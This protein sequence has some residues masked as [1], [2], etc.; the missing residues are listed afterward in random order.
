MRRIVA[1]IG[2][3]LLALTPSLWADTLT[4]V[5]DD[6][7]PFNCAPDSDAPGF[8]VETA[9]QAFALSGYTIKYGTRPW[10]RAISDVR[11]GKY[12]GLVGAGTK[13]APDFVFPKLALAMARH[14][15]F[16]RPDS[17][18]RYKN[19]ASLSLI[20]LGVID[21]YSYG[22]LNDRYIAPNRN[23]R[24]HLMILNGQNVLGRFLNMLEIQRIDAFVEEEAVLLN[25]MKTTRSTLNVRKAG[26][27][28]RE[29]IFIAFS[30]ANP[31][32]QKYAD[33]LDRGMRALKASGE[34]DALATKYGINLKSNRLSRPIRP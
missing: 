24:E 16:T 32:S 7:C 5:A 2:F 26:V 29:P 14:T 10:S 4:L 12:D 15:F 23:D 11:N 17:V 25:F 19:A 27:A 30:P 3:F 20:K 34:L 6:W 33:A 13:D 22:E 9:E 21:D 31:D 1:T 18:W 28:Y 8:L